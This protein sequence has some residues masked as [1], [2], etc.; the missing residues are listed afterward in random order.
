[1]V[2]TG[3]IVR[4]GLVVFKSERKVMTDRTGEGGSVGIE[5]LNLKQRAGEEF[6]N[7]FVAG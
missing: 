5:I 4:N 3:V 7:D 1:M 6:S 2:Q